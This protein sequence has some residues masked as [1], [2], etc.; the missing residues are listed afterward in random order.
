MRARHE[1][2]PR[3]NAACPDELGPLV[4]IQV[5]QVVSGRGEHQAQ[6]RHPVGDTFEGLPTKSMASVEA[7]GGYQVASVSARLLAL[8][9]ETAVQP[10]LV[11]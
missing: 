7:F 3:G 1:S 9:L 10:D 11:A 4:G 5:V 6:V 2:A 8:T